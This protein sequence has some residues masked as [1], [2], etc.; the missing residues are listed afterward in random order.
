MYAQD[1]QNL[2][3]ATRSFGGVAC[4]ALPRAT[5]YVESRDWFTKRF[6]SAKHPERAW[7]ES[8]EVPLAFLVKE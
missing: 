6:P 4:D 8:A 3:A 2:F 1:G 5:G 7:R